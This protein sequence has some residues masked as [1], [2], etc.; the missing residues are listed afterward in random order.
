MRHATR[1]RH[2]MQMRSG[3]FLS[4]LADRLSTL[5]TLVGSTGERRTV[6][7]RKGGLERALRDAARRGE[8][9]I[10]EG[11]R[12]SSEVKTEGIPLMNMQGKLISKM[13]FYGDVLARMQVRL[14]FFGR[15]NV[16]VARNTLFFFK[17]GL[18]VSAAPL[19]A[20]YESD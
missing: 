8:G 9:R 7:I 18:P 10:M 11:R 19:V 13:I 20:S 15:I 12:S 2:S 6:S 4:G 5:F 16:R 3:F 14:S 1:D 17:C